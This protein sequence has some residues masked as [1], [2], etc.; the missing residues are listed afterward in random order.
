MGDGL[1]RRLSDHKQASIVN[2]LLHKILVTQIKASLST[3]HDCQPRRERL[4]LV[5]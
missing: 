2:Y 1:A 3:A 5:A 4:A